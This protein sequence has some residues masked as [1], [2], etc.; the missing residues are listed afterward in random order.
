MQIND[1]VEG[2]Y[3]ASSG[4]NMGVFKATG[5]L[6]DVARLTAGYRTGAS[7]RIHRVGGV[8]LIHSTS[9]TGASSTTER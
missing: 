4:K 3:V 5:L 2:A 9:W 6:C 8:E 7:R 1:C